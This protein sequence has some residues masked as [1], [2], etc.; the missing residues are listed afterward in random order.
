MPKKVF[1]PVA[2]VVMGFI[3]IASNLD[4]LPA[5]FSELWPIILVVVGLGGLITSDQDEWMCCNKKAAKKASKK[6]AKKT[7]KH[8][9]KKK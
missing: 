7:A 6:K 9:S 2:L 3:I 4:L 8:S 5:T 1:W